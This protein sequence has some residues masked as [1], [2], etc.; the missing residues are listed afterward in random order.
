[1]SRIF[2]DGFESG[3]SNLWTTK[4]VTGVVAS[5]AMVGAYYLDLYAGTAMS[6]YVSK[7]LSSSYSEL[8]VAFKYKA[9]SLDNTSIISFK[10]SAGTALA[11]F[12]LN[13]TTGRIESHL[14]ISTGTLLATGTTA[15]VAGTVYL[16]E[17]RYKP[18][19]SNGIIQVKV[20]GGAFEIDYSGDTTNG[21]EYVQEII[22]G[23]A[24]GDSTNSYAYLD[25]VVVDDASWIGS[26]SIQGLAVTGAGAT[27][28]F[29]PSAGNNYQCVDE[30]PASDA[31]YISTNVPDEIDTYACGNLTGTINSVKA[32]QV[33]A[34]CMQEGSPAVPKIQLVT[35]PSDTDRV[36]AS[37]TVQTF[38]PG[39]VSNIWELNP[40]DSAAWSEADVNGMEI[41]VKAVAS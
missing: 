11:T 5:S 4:Y 39:V 19:N 14:G 3:D 26:T 20:N 28:Q 30:I 41:G 23:R 29:D 9:L 8:Y 24:P 13:G 12:K 36:S 27:T 16:I 38:A 31:D 10:D 25:D 7:Y 33:Q 35:R 2:M 40:D 32:V 1:M 37:K 18:L 34:R 21:L 22:F 6:A 17:I 15:I